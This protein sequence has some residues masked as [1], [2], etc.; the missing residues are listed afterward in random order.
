MEVGPPSTPLNMTHDSVILEMVKKASADKLQDE[1]DLTPKANEVSGARS[2]SIGSF[3]KS[4]LFRSSDS[5]N[6][7]KLAPI[8]RMN[9]ES[10]KIDAPQKMEQND[11][12]GTFGRT[13]SYIG[14]DS[15]ED[16][17][18][19]PS[20]VKRQMSRGRRLLLE[21]R[22]GSTRIK[23]SFIG[24]RDSSES[25]RYE[26]SQVGHKRDSSRSSQKSFESIRSPS[27]SSS[28]TLPNHLINGCGTS[29]ILALDISIIPQVYS[30]DVG[31]TSTIW[32]AVKL[33]GVVRGFGSHSQR[34]V[35][36]I[37]DDDINHCLTDPAARGVLISIQ[38]LVKLTIIS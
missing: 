21:A 32:I 27:Y 13:N 4:E 26:A 31:K 28:A 38:L 10:P 5:D 16:D 25:F 14:D 3:V 35:C 30:I 18:P 1:G 19:E 23:N 9:Q 8:H 34:K 37:W 12:T 11:A 20:D 33:E 17:H 29:Q 15:N 7:S 24:P 6:K 2:F 36:Y 22:N